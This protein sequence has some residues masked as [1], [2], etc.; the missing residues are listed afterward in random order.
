MNTYV[1][2]RELMNTTVRTMEVHF[3]GAI[4]CYLI[5]AAI[6]ML[7]MVSASY[8]VVLVLQ[9]EGYATQFFCLKVST[10]PE[11]LESL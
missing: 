6:N 4:Q 11:N 3:R 8:T 2:Y 9:L 7:D 10:L 5:R 1:L